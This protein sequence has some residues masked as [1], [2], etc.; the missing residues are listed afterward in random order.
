MLEDLSLRIGNTTFQ[1]IEGEESKLSANAEAF[2]D[3]EVDLSP[4][5]SASCVFRCITNSV[6]VKVYG[7][8]DPTYSDQVVLSTKTLQPGTPQSELLINPAYRFLRFSLASAVAGAHGTATIHLDL[9]WKTQHSVYWDDMLVSAG[10]L[11]QGAVPADAIDYGPFGANR[12]RALGFAV[13]EDMNGSLQFSHRYK[14]G[15]DIEFHVHWCPVGTGGGNVKWRL[16]YYWQNINDA[17]VGAPT[18]IEVE[19]AA[20]TTAWSQKISGF[21]TIVGTEKKISS[22]IMFKLSRVAAS[23]SELAG[24]ACVLS[25]DAHFQIDAPGSRSTLVK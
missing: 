7:A 11:S 12:P 15:T 17:V 3:T 20:G 4:F 1:I 16:S 2:F 9:G 10:A 13:G 18:D 14:E 25:V 5:T 23:T 8:N 22:I 6:I 19:A 21:P 24:D